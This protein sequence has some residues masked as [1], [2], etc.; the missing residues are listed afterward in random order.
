VEPLIWVVPTGNSTLNCSRIAD[1]GREKNAMFFIMP[2][3]HGVPV[4]S[5]WMTSLVRNSSKHLSKCPP[6]LF[7][8]TIYF[9]IVTNHDEIGVGPIQAG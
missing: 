4:R 1:R 6:L 7:S 9:L 2:W 8:K 3:C 5:Y